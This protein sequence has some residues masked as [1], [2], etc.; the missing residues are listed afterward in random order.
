MTVP[1]IGVVIPAYNAAAT[2]PRAVDSVLRQTCTD[3]EIVIVDDGST[4]DLAASLA[5]YGDR[6]RLIRQ[7][8]SG[9]AAAR[10]RGVQEARGRG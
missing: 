7:Q 4:E 2:L 10:N 3:F 8:N 9:A 1:W 6:V 5:A